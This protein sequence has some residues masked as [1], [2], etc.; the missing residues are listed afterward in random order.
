[1][2]SVV[3]NQ[4]QLNSWIIQA[5]VQNDPW[6]STLDATKDKDQCVQISGSSSSDAVVTGSE[7]CLHINVYTTDASYLNITLH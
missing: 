5:P 7:D 3:I 2:S 6:K 1:M 4:K